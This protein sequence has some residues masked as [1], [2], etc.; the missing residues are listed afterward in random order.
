M[1]KED[2]KDTLDSCTSLLDDYNKQ[3]KDQ[4]SDIEKLK[5]DFALGEDEDD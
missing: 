1:S 2:K 5:L 4:I 3:N